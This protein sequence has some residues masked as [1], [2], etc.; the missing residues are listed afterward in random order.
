M[1]EADDESEPLED[2]LDVSFAFEVDTRR[3]ASVCAF[4]FFFDFLDFC[5]SESESSSS[6]SE[7]ATRLPP[8]G[9]DLDFAFEVDFECFER[10]ESGFDGRDENARS[11]SLSART[12]EARSL[13]AE[14]DDDDA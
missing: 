2:E 11:A 1:P 13:T 12:P 3:R 14:D 6:P 7:N 5:P 8:G 9:P 10:F 4:D